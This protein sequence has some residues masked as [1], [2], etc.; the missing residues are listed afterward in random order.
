MGWTFNVTTP[1]DRDEVR[2][3]IGDTRHN[4][5]PAPD[6]SN[7][8]DALLDYFLEAAGTIP[9]AVALAFDHLSALWVSRPVF[10]PGELS[11]THADISR[12]YAEQAREWRKR[13]SGDGGE[14]GTE[15]VVRVGRFNRVD[16]Y[17]NGNG[18][19]T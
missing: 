2:I 17:S 14:L 15:T 3:H 13:D 4:D 6:R 8:D 10:G 19:Y 7:L 12:K 9:G 11:T 18:E 1:T 16:G 5:G